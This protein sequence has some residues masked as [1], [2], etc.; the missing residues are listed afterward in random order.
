VVVSSSAGVQSDAGSNARFQ[1]P[2]A[3]LTAKVAFLSEPGAFG[4]GA[5]VKI[6]E[7]HMS[8]IFLTED[9]A[10]KLK[11]PV[12]FPYLDFSTVALRERYCRAELA[13]N[14]RLAPDV[15]LRVVPL[16]L[17]EGQALQIGDEGETVDWLVEMR[18]L[19]TDRMLDRLIEGRL[20]DDQ[21]IT[22]LA[23]RLG[24]FYRAAQRV[25]VSPPAYVSRLE[26][27]QRLNRGAL[28][29]E[30]FPIDQE[31]AIRVLNRV[32]KALAA[33]RSRLEARA[34]LGCLVDGHG[35]LRP[36]HICFQDG[37]IIFDCLEFSEVLRQV[38][39]VDEIA[40]LDIECSRLGADWIGTEVWRILRELLDWSD[41]VPLFAV[42]AARRAL[43][44][45]RLALS[46][47]FDPEPRDIDKWAPLTTQYL[48]LAERAMDQL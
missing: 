47:L 10:F 42:H 33:H 45:A 27:E 11:K 17:N 30:G 28:S 34:A 44:R 18:R 43:L 20:V 8:W 1:P 19:P 23:A 29:R 37:V 12:K 4:A 31:R 2:G 13:L 5:A 41:P 25:K 21:T 26:A 48:G 35:D 46:H 39:P 16:T 40:Y 38:D 9:R 14:R 7:T 22:R 24:S 36:E 15:Y 3:N 6:V 32:D